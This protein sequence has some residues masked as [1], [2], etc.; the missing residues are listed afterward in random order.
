VEKKEIGMRKEV[1]ILHEEK[2]ARIFIKF[3][4]VHLEV[5]KERIEM[6]L[7]VLRKAL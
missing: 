4:D 5:Q 3:F 6:T 1:V 2:Q 7:F